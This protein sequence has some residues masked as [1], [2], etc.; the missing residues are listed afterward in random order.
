MTAANL[1]A[2]IHQ[3]LWNKRALCP[4]KL[5]TCKHVTLALSQGKLCT[6]KCVTLFQ[7]FHRGRLSF[8]QHIA[9][10]FQPTF[11][12]SKMDRCFFKTALFTRFLKVVTATSNLIIKV[13]N[14]GFVTEF[15][16]SVLKETMQRHYQK[17]G[18]RKQN[19]QKNICEN[20]L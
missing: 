14:G 16:V 13:Y 1:V 7:S 3:K 4:E 6:C 11:S 12:M 15:S 17:L 20:K 18:N 2:E 5:C 19:Q 9:Q 8:H 10:N